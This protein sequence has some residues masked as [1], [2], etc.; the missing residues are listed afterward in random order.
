M[1][2]YD[3]TIAQQEHRDY[4]VWYQAGSGGF[5]VSWLVQLVIDESLI[6]QALYCFPEVLRDTPLT[7]KDYEITPPTVALLCNLFHNTTN[8]DV[9]KATYMSLARLKSGNKRIT[10]ALEGEQRLK[11]F[12]YNYV[13]KCANYKKKP[14]NP[15]TYKH[16]DGT[17][18]HIIRLSDILYNPTKTIIVSAPTWFT[19]LCQSTKAGLNDYGKI[20]Y[21]GYAGIDKTYY[22]GPTVKKF[23][24][25][26]LT[27][28]T[29]SIWEGTWKRELEKIFKITLSASQ[30]KKCQRLIDRWLYISP[31]PIRRKLNIL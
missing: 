1:K 20:E 8:D 29:E 24:K 16:Y 6:D 7:W 17:L 21:C 19:K 23:S 9:A 4:V 3:S 13:W 26:L 25:E 5:L 12:F 27:F 31:E 14:W 22:I 11:F 28:N 18:D 10:S 30:I 15:Y 2:L